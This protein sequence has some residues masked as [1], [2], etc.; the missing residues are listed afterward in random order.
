V[1]VPGLDVW[2]KATGGQKVAEPKSVVLN[3]ASPAY[4]KARGTFRAFRLLGG[5]NRSAVRS[6]SGIS[7]RAVSSRTALTHEPGHR[8]GSRSLRS[9][10]GDERGQVLPLLIVVIIALLAAGVLVF[11]LGFS[12]SIATN[13]QTAADA[14]ALAAE[15]SVD[16]QW[17]ELINVNGVLEPRDS[18]DSY[19][20]QKDARQLAS[21]NHGMVTSIEYCSQSSQSCSP[22]PIYTSEP[23]VLVS[24]KSVQTL[25]GGSVSPGTGATA[26]ARAS[27]DPYAQASPSLG[28]LGTSTIC[29]PS[30]VPPP[31][32]YTAPSGHQAGFV[33]AP[34]TKFD[35]A[36]ACEYSLAAHLDALG[37][38]LGVQ[39]VGVWG[40][41]AD[42]P[43]GQGQK[44]PD[45]VVKAHACGALAEV[46]DLPASVTKTQLAR[47]AMARFPGQPDE[48]QFVDPTAR[49]AT[50]ATLPA[51][52]A[53][54]QQPSVGNGKVHL[55][56][57]TG[58]PQG[59]AVLGIGAIS[60]V[61]P[62]PAIS[63]YM[64]IFEAL[65]KQYG[66][67]QA[68]LQDW[69]A[70]EQIE[71]APGI[72]GTASDGAF[73]LAQFHGANICSPLYGPGDCP[74]D[75]PTAAQELASMASYISQRYGDPAA[76]L[77]NELDHN[78][79]WY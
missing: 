12:T 66:W 22:Q 39:I 60:G 17:N 19:L 8:A 71:D 78:P 68:Q 3:E 53:S 49:C 40:A 32:R 24:V 15:Q 43:A 27:T 72:L 42:N 33:A 5:P 46:E 25:P 36:D 74:Q 26:Q 73:G 79:H 47:W 34:D 45:A 58:G 59:A 54:D 10:A 6:K 41:G 63:S 57:L 28:P 20:V 44:T 75:N 4:R 21:D 18:Y 76:A 65:A 23:D 1:G 29:D 52:G 13:A 35:P 48:I 62:W 2:F 61:G 77:Q 11:W 51:Q 56:A 9:L 69:L 67:D 16:S 55:V 70:V 38:Q 7:D 64:P 50:N 30:V 37:K 14:A 31:T